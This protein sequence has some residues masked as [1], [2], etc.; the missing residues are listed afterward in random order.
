MKKPYAL[1]FDGVIR[2]RGVRAAPLGPIT[3]GLE[4]VE[5]L[6]ARGDHVV[7]YTSRSRE[8]VAEWLRTNG[9]PPLR[10]AST[11]AGCLYISELAPK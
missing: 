4:C 7:V 5:V 3:D 9:F 6:L 11:H 1:D 10:I 8:I 2:K